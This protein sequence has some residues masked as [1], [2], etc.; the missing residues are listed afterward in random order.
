MTSILSSSNTAPVDNG[1]LALSI[2]EA[3]KKLTQTNVSALWEENV[4]SLSGWNIL[5]KFY[6]LCVYFL[7]KGEAVKAD[8]KDGGAADFNGKLASLVETVAKR[9]LTDGEADAAGVPRLQYTNGKQ[10]QI[11]AA[12]TKGVDDA[13]SRF[14]DAFK[15]R[16][17]VLGVSWDDKEFKQLIQATFKEMS[18]QALNPDL[19]KRHRIPEAILSL[20]MKSEEHNFLNKLYQNML[21][22][23]AGRVDGISPESFDKEVKLISSYFEK[24]VTPDEMIRR[25]LC[26]SIDKEHKTKLTKLAADYAKP[27]DPKVVEIKKHLIDDLNS[28]RAKMQEEVDE[29]RGSTGHNGKVHAAY[30]K[31]QDAHTPYATAATKFRD[32]YQAVYNNIPVT[33]NIEQLIPLEIQGPETP[34]KAALRDARD[35]LVAAQKIYKEAEAELTKLS[36]RLA[37]LAEYDSDQNL[38]RGDLYKL[39]QERIPNVATEAVERGAALSQFYNKLLTPPAL[40]APLADVKTWSSELEQIIKDATERS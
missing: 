3:Q 15:K 20:K 38:F 37:K 12:D 16:C 13:L 19:A 24:E 5:G 17:K 23:Y 18:K 28:K 25:D 14:Y 33:T 2:D 26:V 30:Q 40:D 39:N 9:V 35:K 34:N 4:G 21:T 31:F 10:Q 36:E 7:Y 11:S 27:A 6:G 32:A 8:E 1:K 22:A 29:L